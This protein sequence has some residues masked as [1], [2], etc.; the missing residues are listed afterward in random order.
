MVLARTLALL[1]VLFALINSPPSRA[2]AADNSAEVVN[3]AYSAIIGTGFYKVADRDIY[4][5]RM[6]FSGRGREANAPQ[7]GSRPYEIRWLLPVTLGL[8]D[9]DPGDIEELPGAGNIG[10]ITALPGIGAEVYRPSGWR[11]KSFAQ[12]GAG[13]DLDNNL[14]STLYAAGAT[15]SYP[16]RPLSH[17]S[18]GITF[19]QGF[20]LAGSDTEKGRRTSLGYVSMGL[21]FRFRPKWRLLDRTPYL[22]LSVWGDL[23]FRKAR[24]LG[25]FD[26]PEE[27]SR[28]YTIGL[29]IGGEPAFEALGIRFNRLG[30]GVKFGPNVRALTVFSSFP[31]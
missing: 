15:G 16:V 11:L 21:D 6:P 19:G 28:V 22:G 5:V 10:T 20:T 23:Y 7:D 18:F 26:K 25:I 4:V 31:F 27:I 17:D 12:Y 2:D 9:F 30:V 14:W 8:Y 24:F 1:P 3:Y 13:R 29:S